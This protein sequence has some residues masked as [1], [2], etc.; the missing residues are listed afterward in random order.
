MINARSPHPPNPQGLVWYMRARNSNSGWTSSLA[1]G[2]SVH[3]P[4]AVELLRFLG[5]TG[6]VLH[7]DF[8][9]ILPGL[10]CFMKRIQDQF[11]P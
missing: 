1:V 7:T 2:R 6:M 10:A 3:E 9:A 4:A 8:R 11:V 5:P